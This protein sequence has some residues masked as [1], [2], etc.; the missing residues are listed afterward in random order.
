MLDRKSIYSLNKADSDAIVYTDADGNIIRLTRQCFSTD[1]EFKKWKAW[2][3]EDF[4][5][6]EKK[7]HLYSW[8]LSS[9]TVS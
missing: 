8:V 6:E 3:D 9:A 4:H 2:S 1:E 5:A 7:D